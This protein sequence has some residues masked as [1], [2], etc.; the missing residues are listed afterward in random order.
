M[1]LSR[2]PADSFKAVRGSRNCQFRTSEEQPSDE[3]ATHDSG[4]EYTLSDDSSLSSRSPPYSS[5]HDSSASSDTSDSSDSSSSSQSSDSSESSLD[6]RRRLH[7]LRQARY[8]ARKR[9]H[10]HKLHG[11]TPLKTTPVLASVVSKR[12]LSSTAHLSP[13]VLPVTK[14]QVLKQSQQPVLATVVTASHTIEQKHVISLS[15]FTQ[16]LPFM[17]P[18]T[19]GGSPARAV[20]ASLPP[21]VNSFSSSSAV[22]D[23]P[24]PF[25]NV[26]VDLFY[27]IISF[28]HPM[29]LLRV[30]GVSSAANVSTSD[31]AIWRPL[32]DRPWP[33]T[34]NH[35]HDWKRVYC[36]RI[37]RALTGARYLCTFCACTRTFKQDGMLE[38]HMIK[39][40]QQ[41]TVYPCTVAGCGLSFDTARKLRYHVKRHTAGV[42]AKK[43]HACD[44]SGCQLAFP[45]PYALS[46][47][48]CRHT[49]EKR[50]HACKHDGCTR[51]FNSRHALALHIDTHRAKDERTQ[52]F[53]CSV[54]SCD[55]VFLTKSGLSKH[56]V[57]RHSVAV[58]QR[59]AR[60]VCE[61]EGC[62]RQFMYKSEWRKT[63][64]DEAPAC[65]CGRGECEG[66]R[67]G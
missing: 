37:K 13:T 2:K 57:K 49:G 23:I 46:L 43:L 38:A 35:A 47:H 66:G 25:L 10:E 12:R 15:Q 55:R 42:L 51:S 67:G 20:A 31:P 58:T 64:G 5:S 18:L 41:P 16:Q 50:P 39:H 7:R 65:G 48:R 21:F 28:L 44:W 63:Y 34:C 24:E 9:Q 36:T 3:S 33:I 45:T 60:L 8:A 62:G 27:V 11:Q 17:S 6:R 40:S 52:S 1:S 54:A 61:V 22:I 26:S 14:A 32:V 19:L 59:S 4:S 29:D 53:P 56:I 30:S